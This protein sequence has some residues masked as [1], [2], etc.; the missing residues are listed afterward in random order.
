MGLFGFKV[1]FRG[2]RIDTKSVEDLRRLRLRLQA[3][4]GTIVRIVDIVAV[5][6]LA[7]VRSVILPRTT[8]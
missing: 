6:A 1:G 5:A 8:C 3:C 4:L 2:S 7:S